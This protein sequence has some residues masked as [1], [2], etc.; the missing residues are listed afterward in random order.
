[1]NYNIP[2]HKSGEFYAMRFDL[3]LTVKT[4]FESQRSQRAIKVKIALKAQGCNIHDPGA[5]PR[6]SS[7][8]SPIHLLVLCFTAPIIPKALGRVFSPETKQNKYGPGIVGTICRPSARGFFLSSVVSGTQILSKF[9]AQKKTFR[10][11]TIMSTKVNC[12]TR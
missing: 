10:Y 6:L 1:M 8:H 5:Q 7:P 12:V 9:A 2:G 11:M 4:V 3:V